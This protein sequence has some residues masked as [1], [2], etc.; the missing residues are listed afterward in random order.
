ML[1]QTAWATRVPV[2]LATPALVVGFT[3]AW[4]VVHTQDLEAMLTPAQAVG[5]IPALAVESLKAQGEAAM[6]AQG[7]ILMNGT[8]QIQTVSDPEINRQRNSNQKP[9]S[10]LNRSAVINRFHCLVSVSLPVSS[11]LGIEHE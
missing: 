9:N 4:V 2:G 11:A 3:L 7:A 10:A 8:V 6:L 1:S 5:L